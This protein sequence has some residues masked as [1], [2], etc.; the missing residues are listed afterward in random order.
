MTPFEAYSM[1]LSLKLHF[2]SESY[3]YFKYNGKTGARGDKFDTRRDKYQFYKL[4]KIDDLQLY[5]VAN[6]FESTEGWVGDLFTDKAKLRHAEMAKRH[7]SLNYLLTRELSSISSFKEVIQCKGRHPP[8]LKSFAQDKISPETL[9]LL[10]REM[11]I[12]SYWDTKIDEE[13]VWPT[14][15]LKLQKYGP[16]VQ[17]SRKKMRDLLRSHIN[18]IEE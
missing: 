6:F 11:K 9:V 17:F 5:L 10:D 12:F 8:L 14:I 13:Y 1:Y 3:D 7:Q 4:S 16:F 18:N 2:S 15:K